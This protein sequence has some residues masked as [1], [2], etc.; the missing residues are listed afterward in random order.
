[1]FA[2]AYM[3]R[4]R[5]GEAPPKLFNSVPA[6]NGRVGHISLVFREMWDTATLPEKFL[7]T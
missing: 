7:M 5:R 4:K 3:G 2:L 6:T 1:M